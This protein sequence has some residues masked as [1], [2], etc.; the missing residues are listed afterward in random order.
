MLAR[1]GT[2]VFLA[3]LA[4]EPELPTLSLA[5]ERMVTTSANNDYED[6]QTGLD[7]LTSGRVNVKPLITHRF[8]LSDVTEAFEVA[9]NKARYQALKV[10]IEI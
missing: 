10:I 5:G 2:A 8:P 6:F 7:L 4:V 9:R 3:D 1:G